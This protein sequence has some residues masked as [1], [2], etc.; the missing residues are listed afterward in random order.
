MFS[1]EAVLVA[2]DDLPEVG[3]LLLLKCYAHDGLDA[4]EA[5]FPDGKN[6]KWIYI[7]YD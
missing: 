5:V 4:L 2:V 7:K 3:R 1:P 6:I